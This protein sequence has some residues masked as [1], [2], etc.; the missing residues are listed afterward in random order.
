MASSGEGMAVGAASGTS[1]CNWRYT[2]SAGQAGERKTTHLRIR[3]Q[4]LSGPSLSFSG[5]AS[6]TTSIFFLLLLFGFILNEFLLL[7]QD[8]QFL[9]V[10]GVVRVDFKFGFVELFVALTR[11]KRAR[12]NGNSPSCRA[13]H[14]ARFPGLRSQQSFRLRHRQSCGQ[15]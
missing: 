7:L 15:S 12:G 2:M 8:F 4:S 14:R 6:S 11:R 10:A 13:D 3:E 5:F 1:G 9:L